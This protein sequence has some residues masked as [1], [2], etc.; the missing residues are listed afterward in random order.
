MCPVHMVHHVHILYRDSSLFLI[1]HD[2]WMKRCIPLK[3]VAVATD[4]WLCLAQRLETRAKTYR[5]ARSKSKTNLWIY[6]F[7][8]LSEAERMVRHT[9]IHNCTIIFT[10]NGL[11]EQ[12]KYC[13]HVIQWCCAP[14]CMS[15]C[16]TA[17]LNQI[18]L[19][20]KYLRL[21][22]FYA[23]SVHDSVLS[24]YC[25]VLLYLWFVCHPFALVKVV[26]LHKK[27]MNKQKTTN[28]K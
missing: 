21:S 25:F 27:Q 19:K 14:A 3:Y 24:E 4:T 23:S 17:K 6:V 2:F 20:E 5:L 18:Q 26:F 1:E 16:V 11:N 9:Q 10:C 8:C 7:K 12:P 13:A 28:L 15:C 22:L